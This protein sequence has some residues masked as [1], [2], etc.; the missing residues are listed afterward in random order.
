MGGDPPPDDPT[1]SLVARF[2]KGDGAA[3]RALVD[4]YRPAIVAFCRRYVGDEAEDAAQEVFR[5]AIEAR[6]AP[7][8][9]RA[10]LFRVARNH[11]LNLLRAGRRGASPL[12]S[13]SGLRDAASGPLTHLVREEQREAFADA[14]A[15]LPEAQREALLLRYGDGL[16]RGEIAEVLGVPESV[17]K[18]RLF[19]GMKRL[20]ARLP[21]PSRG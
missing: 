7:E 6:E 19:E 11:C 10:W 2:R 9:F 15:S 5:R 1:S 12:P 8:R 17:V 4:R 16:A 21:P 3:G 20:R 14:L 18:S 13:A